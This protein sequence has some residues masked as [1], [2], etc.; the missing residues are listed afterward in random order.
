MTD[1]ESPGLVNFYCFVVA[2]PAVGILSL[3]TICKNRWRRQSINYEGKKLQQKNQ[4]KKT[5]QQRKSSR[6]NGEEPW[7]RRDVKKRLSVLMDAS[8]IGEGRSKRQ[9][10]V[11]GS[12]WEHRHHR[13]HPSTTILLA[14]P[15]WW[16]C[17]KWRRS[18]SSR[19]S[20]CGHSQLPAPSFHKEES[21]ILLSFFFFFPS[22]SQFPSATL[23]KFSFCNCNFVLQLFCKPFWRNLTKLNF[24][25]AIPTQHTHTHTHTHSLSL[26]LFAIKISATKNVRLWNKNRKICL[27]N[28]PQ[29]NKKPENGFRSFISSWSSRSLC[30]FQTHQA[31]DDDQRPKAKQ[32]VVVS[33]KGLWGN[34]SCLGDWF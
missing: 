3:A 34:C 30:N 9:I 8:S 7:H 16:C 31:L 33:G 5:P 11:A 10:G 14:A 17:H 6:V 22:S 1:I 4:A 13:A 25:N 28:N 27:Y 23:K 19:N 29:K 15:E 32:S 18:S 26:S 12:S 2:S 20:Q 24:Q 21:A